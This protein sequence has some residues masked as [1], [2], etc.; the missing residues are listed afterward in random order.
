MMRA[1]TIAAGLAFLV[2]LCLAAFLCSSVGAATR[3]ASSPAAEDP[4]AIALLGSAG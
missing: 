2:I 1:K 3:G 4:I